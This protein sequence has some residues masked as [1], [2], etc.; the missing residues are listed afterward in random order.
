MATLIGGAAYRDL[1][2]G[3]GFDD[4]RRPL[5]KL[6][7]WH[8]GLLDQAADRR[9]ADIENGRRFFERHFSTLSTLAIA[10][11]GNLA[12][13]AHRTYARA[14]PSLSSPRRLAGPIENGRNRRIR[15]QSRQDAD[16]LDDIR[17]GAPTMLP[18]TVFADL[19]RRVIVARP[20]DHKHQRV[21]LD[22]ND[23]L[24][25]Q[26]PDDPLAGC[27]RRPWTMP[28]ALD[29][30][31]KGE[32]LVP[33]GGAQRGLGRSIEDIPLLFKMLNG[34]E[35]LVPPMFEFARHETVVGIDGI[36]LPPRASDFKARLFESQL[37]LTSVLGMFDPALLDSGNRRLDTKRLKA[38]DHLD[39]DIPVDP[40]PAERD[41]RVAAVVDLTA[42]AMIAAR[43]ATVPAIGNVEF[44]TAMATTKQ[45]G[46]QSLATPHCGA[47]QSG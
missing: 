2:E 31:S 33:V 28:C 3:A 22:A 26:R 45:T 27:R 13:I 36:V 38:A 44:A 6:L 1:V 42:A 23:D 30:R 41:T 9:L 5:A 25:D 35:T 4:P 15:H 43:T 34:E 16:K 11:G 18:N 19:Q 46:K 12:M 37:D 14:G 47:R 39:A 24:L 40:H 29:I 20:P 17:V 10:I 32:K 7:R 21:G 8:D